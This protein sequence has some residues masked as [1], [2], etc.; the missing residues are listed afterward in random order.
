MVRQLSGDVDTEYLYFLSSLPKQLGYPACLDKRNCLKQRRSS[1]LKG[2]QNIMFQLAIQKSGRLSEDS[3]NLVK[4]CGIALNRHDNRL[5]TQALNFPIEIL[6]LRDDDIPEYIADGV[7]D[8]GIV[9]ENMLIESKKEVV[10]VEKLG[11]SKCRLCMA[12]PNSATYDGI[13]TLNGKSIATS[14]PVSLQKFLDTHNIKATIKVISGS[15]EIAPSIGLA[16]AICDIVSSGSTLISNGLR[17]V[18]TVLKSEAV[19]ARHKTLS[20][21][22]NKI[23]EDLLFRIQAVLRARRFKYILLNAPD[24]KLNNI[25][26]ALPGLRAPT[27]M[28]LAESGW[29]SVHTV[30]QED[31]FWEKIGKLKDAGAEGILVLPIEKLIY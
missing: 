5:K 13:N 18:E 10:V 26:A 20:P 21:E 2:Y 8:A 17:E 9:G 29:S 11:F 24:A 31:Q 1:I 3:L 30:I 22:K 23:F 27:V 4:E 15:T 19:L 28:P 6:F 16:D 25:I 7:V 14:Y 12:V